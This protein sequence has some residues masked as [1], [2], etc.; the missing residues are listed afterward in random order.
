MVHFPDKLLRSEKFKALARACEAAG[1]PCEM[2]FDIEIEDERRYYWCEIILKIRPSVQ[3]I[4]GEA[5]V[6]NGVLRLAG[7]DLDDKLF[8]QIEQYTE[9]LK[10]KSDE[11]RKA[12]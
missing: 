6:I 3:L 9:V 2:D 11:I 10:L 12:A 8:K 7:T 1:V 4:L 5:R